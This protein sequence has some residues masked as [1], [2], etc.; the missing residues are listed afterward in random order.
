MDRV[1]YFATGLGTED[2]ECRMFS[3]YGNVGNGNTECA[4]DTTSFTSKPE[5][6]KEL[7]RISIRKLDDVAQTF[8]PFGRIGV[9]KIDT[10]GYETKVFEG[11]WKFF[12]EN[13]IPYIRT[14]FSPPMLSWD[15][16]K[17]K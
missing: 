1:Q 17:C 15:V 3:A 12:E 10:E 2:A 6:F 8:K 4:P 14:E 7:A 11:G 13:K 5:I 9:M 16:K